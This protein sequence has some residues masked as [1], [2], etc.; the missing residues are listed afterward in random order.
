MKDGVL[1]QWLLTNY[2]ARK[3]GLKSTGHAGGI[4][5]WRIAGQGLNFEQL[6]KRWAPAWW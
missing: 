2:S 6:L 4:H 5:N 1:T 3:L